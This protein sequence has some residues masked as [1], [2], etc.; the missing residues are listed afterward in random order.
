YDGDNSAFPP[1]PGVQV[2]PPGSAEIERVFADYFEAQGLTSEPTPFSGRSDYG[3]F[4]T[5]APGAPTSWIPAGGLFTGAEGIKTAAQVLTYGGVAGQQYDPCYHLACDTF[6]GT[7]LGSPWVG[8]IGLDQMSD[9]AAHAV[10]LFSKR[11]FSQEPLTATSLAANAALE[12]RSVGGA[13]DAPSWADEAR[14][15]E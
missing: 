3:P 7:G 1:G 4:I 12:Q 10:L 14:L 11:N 9:A 13:T 8:L 6:A 15:A 2:G 5:P